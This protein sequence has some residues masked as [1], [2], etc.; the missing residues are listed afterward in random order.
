MPPAGPVLIY[1]DDRIYLAGVLAEKLVQAGHQ[2]IFA[3]PDS[4]VSSFASNTLEQ[5]RIQARL[6]ELGVDIRCN[7]TLAAVSHGSATLNCTYSGRPDS[8]DCASVLLVTERHRNT[9]LFDA[10]KPLN[11]T[12]M[13][14]IGDAAQP[15]LIVD[16]VFSGHSAAR[17]FERPKSE[18]EQHWFR[19]ETIDLFEDYA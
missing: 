11:L 9:D 10:L 4:I 12:T 2:V 15:G 1:D 14:L 16:A 8:L 6:I 3:T 18:A 17:Q 5:Y 19:R 7:R 13:E